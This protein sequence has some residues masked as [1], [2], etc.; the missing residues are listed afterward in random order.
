MKFIAIRAR[1]RRHYRGMCFIV[2]QMILHAYR[3]RLGKQIVS[4]ALAVCQQIRAEYCG[5]SAASSSRTRVGSSVTV[6]I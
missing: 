6:E 5:R 3:Y 1:R 4:G 2:H